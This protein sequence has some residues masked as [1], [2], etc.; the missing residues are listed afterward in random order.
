MLM[1]HFNLMSV[2]STLSKFL[3][4][5]TEKLKLSNNEH[6]VQVLRLLSSMISI[7]RKADNYVYIDV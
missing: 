1:T 5:V 2:S 6:Y 3:N 4:K 7:G